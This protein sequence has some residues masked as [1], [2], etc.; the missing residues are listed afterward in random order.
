MSPVPRAFAFD[1]TRANREEALVA[2]VGGPRGGVVGVGD[3]GGG[4]EWVGFGGGG[5]GGS[6]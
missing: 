1:C 3:G 6:H 5:V 2:L 4:G